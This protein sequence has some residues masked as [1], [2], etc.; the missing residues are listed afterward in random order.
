VTPRDST[1]ALLNAVRSA[2]AL[3][4]DFDG[5][6]APNLDLAGMKAQVIALTRCWKVPDAE[7]AGAHI[8]EI[9]ELAA[10]WLTQ[11]EGAAPAGLYAREAATLIRD[12]ELDAAADTDPFPTAPPLLMQW[13]KLGRASAVVTRNCR[14]AV[15]ATYPQLNL[16]TDALLARDDVPHLKPDPRHL[17]LAIRQLDVEAGP[18]IM[19]GDGAMDMQIGRALG[20][21][22]L[23]VE[24]GSNTAQA[25]QGAGAHWVAEHIG[26]LLELVHEL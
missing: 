17:R 3:L 14:A 19:V 20:M 11:H 26:A 1:P 16:H 13:R 24:S 7:F 21:Y 18:S 6:L 23:G 15:L 22:C 4:F 25:L 8:V 5:T 9:T 10:A 2:P 12:F